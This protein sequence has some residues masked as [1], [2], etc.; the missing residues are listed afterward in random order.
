[1]LLCYFYVILF[2]F[3]H[4]SWVH[5]IVN[6]FAAPYHLEVQSM[7]QMQCQW[8]DLLLH[9]K[10]KTNKTDIVTFC[11]VLVSPIA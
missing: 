7:L 2:Y 4:M 5:R 1:M 10:K 9:L 11:I 8:M 6:L 3:V